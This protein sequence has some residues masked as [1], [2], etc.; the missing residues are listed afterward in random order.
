MYLSSGYLYWD[1]KIAK[2]SKTN[3]RDI[4]LKSAS[5]KSTNLKNVD[6]SLSK[7]FVHLKVFLYIIFMWTVI[8]IKKKD[9]NTTKNMKG[10]LEL[11][12]FL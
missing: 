1:S 12:Y 3:I 7:H 8:L 2:L 4:Y 10:E 6:H 5:L 11:I 9:H